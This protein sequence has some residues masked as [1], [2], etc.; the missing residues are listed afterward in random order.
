[1]RLEVA[2]PLGAVVAERALVLRRVGSRSVHHLGML[3]EHVRTE[4]THPHAP[5]IAVLAVVSLLG[6]LQVLHGR[7]ILVRL[8]DV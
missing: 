5:E 4:T 2:S 8:V 7:V 3:V 1:M 6:L